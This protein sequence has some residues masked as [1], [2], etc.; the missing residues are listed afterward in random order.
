VAQNPAA[1]QYLAQASLWRSHFEESAPS[2]A[3]ALAEEYPANA[4]LGQAASSV[5]RSLAYFDSAA[6]GTA[7]K[8]EDRLLAANPGNSQNLARIGDIYAEPANSSPRLLLIGSASLVC[9]RARRAVTLKAA[10]ILLGLF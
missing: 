1:G 9:L 7:V 8:I 6:T 5:F 3:K 2:A 4:E 10:T